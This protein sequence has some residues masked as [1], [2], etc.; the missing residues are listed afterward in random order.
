MSVM[1]PNGS[2]LVVSARSVQS[3]LYGSCSSEAT[4]KV[5]FQG[6]TTSCTLNA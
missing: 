4:V 1:Y 6:I 2:L 5:N 3:E